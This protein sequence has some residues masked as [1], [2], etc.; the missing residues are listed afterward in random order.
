VLWISQSEGPIQST[1][2]RSFVLS[3]TIVICPGSD[4]N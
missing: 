1:G 3:S 2:L 4:L